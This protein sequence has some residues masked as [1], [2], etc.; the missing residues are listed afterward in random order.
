MKHLPRISRK[1]WSLPFVLFLVT[2]NF[3]TFQIKHCSLFY[4]LLR[5]LLWDCETLI[6][7]DL[8]LHQGL[9]DLLVKIN[10]HVVKRIGLF[11]SIASTLMNFHLL[12]RHHEILPARV[13]SVKI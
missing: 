3:A 6:L 9:D 10:N 8:N 1:V 11:A 12:E 13:K 5:I 4:I 2:L 7:L